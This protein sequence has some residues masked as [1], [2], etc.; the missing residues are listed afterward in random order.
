MDGAEYQHFHSVNLNGV[1]I[2]EI[3]G[4][5]TKYPSEAQLRHGGAAVTEIQPV[6]TQ[7]INSDSSAVVFVIDSPGGEVTGLP[8][9]VDAVFEAKKSGKK[10][11]AQI[12]GRAAS[13]AYWLAS[14]CDAIYCTH[15]T[16]E[17]GSIGAIRVLTDS[18]KLAERDGIEILVF[19]TGEMKSLGVPGVP[20]TD[21]MKTYIQST[22]DAVYEDFSKAVQRGRKLSAEAVEAISDGRVFRATEAK[23]LGLIDGIQSL[24]T[25]LA[26]LAG[27]YPKRRS[28][29]M[30]GATLAEIK[31]ECPGAS[32]EFVV[33]CMESGADAG[34]VRANWK[35]KTDQIHAETLADNT[36]LKADLTAAQAS[37][38][39][40]TAEVAGLKKKPAS[41]I[42]AG[43]TATQATTEEAEGIS[44]T[45][46]FTALVN[47]EAAKCGSRLK[48]VQAVVRS[49][50]EVHK[51]MLIEAKGVK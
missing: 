2:L 44:A 5:L 26:M 10:V 39:T 28:R 40:L 49:N 32:A 42:P 27:N 3:R 34:Q 46:Q 29:T 12:D 38:A 37:I 41:F 11:I 4:V 1:D 43:G 16:D 9:L 25:T 48:A 31:A 36:K 23:Q 8:G 15:E 21:D 45:D 51:A 17:A 22:V 47:A 14:Q 7:A 30:A 6:F 19:K 13:A 33:Q 35:A 50:P 18:S 24:D 20:I